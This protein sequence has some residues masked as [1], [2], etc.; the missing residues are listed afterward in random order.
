EL[1]CASFLHLGQV[2][3]TSPASFAGSSAASLYPVLNFLLY[4][5]ERLHSPLY[6]RGKDGAPVPTNAFHSPRWGGIMVYNIEPEGA[7]KT[8]LPRTVEVDMVRTME[9]FLAQL[10]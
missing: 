4:I 7:N 10:R 9:V 6:I 2:S 1:T 5:P 8:S 3:P